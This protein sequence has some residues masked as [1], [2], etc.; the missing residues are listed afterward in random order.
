M[1]VLHLTSGNLYGGIETYLLTLARLRHLCPTMEPHFG[2]CFPGRILDELLA[3][4]VG[5]HDL[6]PVRVSRPWTVLRA[7]MRL[8]RLLRDAGFDAVVTHGTWVHGVF[9][10]VVKRSATRVVHAVHGDMTGR[11]WL[12]RWAA[13]TPPDAVIA[14]SRFTGRTAERVFPGCPASVVHPPIPPPAAFDRAATRREIRV[15]SGTPDDA[16]VILMVSRIE[17]LKGHGVLL[18]ALGELRSDSGW[19]CWI[20][21]GA[22]RPHEIELLASLRELAK[23]LGIAD[24]LRFLGQRGDVERVMAG[25]DIYC[26]PN[27]AAEGFGITFIEA[28][29]ANLPVVTSDFGGA[30]E[31]VTPQCGVLCPPG[32]SNSVTMALRALIKD[33]LRRRALGEAGAARADKLCNSGRQM[34]VLAQNTFPRV[35]R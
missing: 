35:T 11:S 32:D 24:R 28:L 2:L 4:G 25:A 17:E 10:S 12:D 27:T 13:R 6:G 8:R 33:P 1:K 15:E 31:I 7:R 14:N 30:S 18:R 29:A 34:S 22:Q 9:G 19:V 23:Q 20:V 5:V 21:G 26:Q 16:T 3:T